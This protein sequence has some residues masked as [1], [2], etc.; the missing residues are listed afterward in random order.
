MPYDNYSFW[1]Y[2][3][4]S[5]H[6]ENTVLQRD[7]NPLTVLSPSN[8]LL[9]AIGNVFYSAAV[10]KRNFTIRH[11]SHRTSTPGLLIHSVQHVVSFKM[12]R[13]TYQFIQYFWWESRCN[14]I[15]NISEEKMIENSKLFLALLLVSLRLVYVE[16][17]L[18]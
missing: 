17:R 15:F 8:S 16:F 6:V 7:R 11:I 3:L 4:S 1:S 12:I 13:T 10:A 18:I 9:M 14:H 5:S 2:S